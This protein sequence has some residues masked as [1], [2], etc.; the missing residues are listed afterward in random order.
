MEVMN[1]TPPRTFATGKNRDIIIKHCADIHLDAD[2]QVT[3]VT[4]SGS[5]YDVVRKSWGY[6]ATP[7]I[8]GRLR[9]MGLRAALVRNPA[10]KVYLLLVEQGK[11]TDFQAYLTAEKQQVMCWLDRDEV[12]CDLEGFLTH[13]SSR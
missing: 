10:G 3:F 12:V 7:S 9:D 2:E 5:Q 13:P 8:N 1:R 6:Y 4:A 11:E